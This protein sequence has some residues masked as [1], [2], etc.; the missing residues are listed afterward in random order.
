MAEYLLEIGT[1]EIP[2]RFIE[3]TL[4]Q[5]KDLVAQALDGRRIVYDTVRALGTPRRLALRIG[6]L[7]LQGE[8]LTE[9]VRGPAQKAAYDNEGKPT[10]ALTGFAGAQGVSPDSLF[11]KE[12][13]GNAYIYASR[14]R[15][16]Q[17][18]AEVLPAILA[19]M[20]SALSFP[21]FMRW[22][23]LDFKFVRPIRWV[24]SLLDGEILPLTLANVH[25]GRQSRGH[26][27][28]GEGAFDLGSA[29]D[30][31]DALERQ[32]V[33]V[34][35]DR[36]KSL[37]REKI[38]EIAEQNGCLAPPDEELLTEVTFLLEWPTALMGSFHESY[39]EIPEEAV[40]TPMREHQRYFPVRDGEGKLINR[41]ITL[42]DGGD[43]MLDLVTEG[44]EKVLA[45]RLSDARFFWDEDRRQLLE[46]WLPKLERVVF[47]EKL[48][49]V[50]DKIRRIEGLTA[51]LAVSLHADADTKAN[52][53]RA[54]HLAKADLATSMVYE[55]A[56]LQGIMG[57][58]YALACGEKPEVAQAVMEHYRPRFA[59]DPPAASPA[60]AFVAIA[61]KAD[62][63][64]GIFAIG[65]E[66]SGSQDP[67]ALRRAAMGV[68]Q[69]ILAHDLPVDLGS[70]VYQA[71]GQYTDVLADE[72]GAQQAYVRIM[73]FFGARIR[74]VLSDEGHRYDVVD[75]V[76]S[77]PFTR[78]QDVRERAQAVSA[79]RGHA[80]FAALLAGFTRAYNLT[81]KS[82][83]DAGDAAP[84]KTGLSAAAT[85]YTQTPA[86]ADME[87][88][89]SD[90]AQAT[91]GPDGSATA[92]SASGVSVSA[93][94]L[95]A[96]DPALFTEEVEM[97]LHA[98][99]LA[100]RAAIGDV[101]REQG[102][103]AAILALA[104]LA[105]PVNAFFDGVMVMAEDPAV[106]A[107]RLGLLREVV[108]LTRLAGDLSKLQ[109]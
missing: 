84:A 70:L 48:G 75:C 62:T 2:A 31:E 80:D 18:T 46:D 94:A 7:A 86:V 100:T 3:N 82:G 1:E 61:D 12:M 11:I 41:F 36:R 64:A 105:E 79:L 92:E 108:S 30:Y 56:E 40:I 73:D 55:F 20:V 21:K 101:L 32:Y 98:R 66:P 10:K 42:R 85:S 93:T 51:W 22:G 78:I 99:L 15:K 24:V 72:D 74:A 4:A 63:I 25:A 14:Q 107:N 13:N 50:G 5:M 54:A 27:Y 29:G 47:Q 77:A 17:S 58:Y 87:S 37:I 65:I 38:G 57:R 67:Y 69:T 23:D 28:L 88:A 45:A 104:N 76:M 96:V 68:C 59:G 6:G 103:S 53:L 106:R 52:A 91:T 8:D 35:P 43:R 90:A 109:D 34:D 16:G 39:L 33:I 97:A 49:T 44:N 102:Q 71:L 89:A 60:G 19:D 9:E 95:V 81:K 26:R 83:E